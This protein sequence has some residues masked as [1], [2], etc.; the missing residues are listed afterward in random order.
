MRDYFVALA[1]DGALVWIYRTR[2]PGPAADAGGG[3]TTAAG[4]CTGALPEGALPAQHDAGL[5]ASRRTGIV[6][7]SMPTHDIFISYRRSDSAGHARAL[8][9]DLAR[10]FD[11]ERIYFDRQTVD[12]GTVYTPKI[13]AAVQAAPVVLVMIGPGWLDTAEAQGRRRLD[14]PADLVRQEVALALQS[15][16]HVIPVLFDDVP[17]PAAA[18]LPPPLQALAGRDAH[19]LRGKNYEYEVQL[20]QLIALIAAVP[21]VTPARE[22]GVLLARGPGEFE[23]YRGLHYAPVRLRAPLRRA[24]DPLVEDRTRIFAGRRQELTRLMDFAAGDEEG[25]LVVTGPPGFGKTALVATLV[26]GTPEAFAYHFFAPVYGA[27][28]LDEKFFLQNVLEQMASWQGAPVELPDDLNALRALYQQFLESGADDGRRQVLVLDGLD[29]ISSWSLRAYLSRRLPPQLRVIATV[30]DVGQD[31][32]SEFGIPAE[33]L[34]TL[35]LDGLQPDDIRE[36]LASQGAAAAQV[37]SEASLMAQ[38]VERAAYEADAALG[39]DPFYVRFLAEDLASGVLK[40]AEVGLQPRGLQ[41]WLDRWWQQLRA[42]AG[43]APVRD[44][45]GTLAAALGPIGRAELEAINPSLKD[46]WAGD[47]FDQILAGVRRFVRCDDEGGYTLAHPRLRTYVADARRI[48]AIERYRELLLAHCEARADAGRT[49]ALS[50]RVG[51]RLLAKQTQGIEM[52]FDADWISAQWRGLDSYAGLMADLRQAA[53]ALLAQATG[54][55]PV[56]A[57]L[58]QVTAPVVAMAIAHQTAREIMGNVPAALMAAWAAAGQTKRALKGLLAQGPARPYAFDALVDVARRLLERGDAGAARDAGALLERAVELLPRQRSDV[59]QLDALVAL[60]PLLRNDRAGLDPALCHALRRR[61]LEFAYTPADPVTLAGA[62][63]AVAQAFDAVT[64]RVDLQTQLERSRTLAADLAPPDHAH[65]LTLALPAWHAFDPAAACDQV[66]AL[67]ALGPKVTDHGSLRKNPLVR[68]IEA[69]DPLIDPATLHTLP[70]QQA[71]PLL[72]QITQLYLQPD[73]H[74]YA[75]AALSALLPML[76]RLGQA[77]AAL[78]HIERLMARDEIGALRSILAAWTTL[79]ALAPARCKQWLEQAVVRVD[80]PRHQL[81]YNRDTFAADVACCLAREQ[82]WDEALALMATL[83]PTHARDAFAA[84]LAAARQGP[85]AMRDATVERIVATLDTTGAAL[86]GKDRAEVLTA[87]AQG[88]APDAAARWLAAATAACLVEVPDGSLDKLRLAH[89]GALVEDGS[90]EA[91]L[92]VAAAMQWPGACGEAIRL[93][94]HHA[95]A[96]AQDACALALIQSVRRHEGAG[97]LPEL[98]GHAVTAVQDLPMSQ[99]SR[100]PLI[101]A[102]GTAL[103]QLRDEDA[104]VLLWQL[105]EPADGGLPIERQCDIL[106]NSMESLG[107]RGEL[108]LAVVGQA[109]SA[110]AR[111]RDVLVPA[112]ETLHGRLRE[113]LAKLAADDSR[114]EVRVAQCRHEAL[115]D[116][117]AGLAAL[118]RLVPEI[119]AGRDVADVSYLMRMLADFTGKAAGRRQVQAQRVEELAGAAVEWLLP[120]GL[121]V[122]DVAHALQ[123]VIDAALAIDDERDRARALVGVTGALGLAPPALAEALAPVLQSW[124]QAPPVQAPAL[125]GA[126][127]Q[128]VAEGLCQAGALGL[129]RML[130][131]L[132]EAATAPWQPAFESELSDAERLAELTPLGPFD[133]A[134]MALRERGLALL[135]LHDCRIRGEAATNLGSLLAAIVDDDGS[136]GRSRLLSSV[137]PFVAVPLRTLG[138]SATIAEVIAQVERLD[139]TLIDAAA[140]VRDAG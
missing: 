102:I 107:A 46:D 59:G 84:L 19:L 118:E 75:H 73:A 28:T 6:G 4:S 9:R 35:A 86:G 130:A 114:L 13:Q 62:Q 112:N 63:A 53:H 51:H 108:E 31:W 138:G 113:L 103:E 132:P 37:A 117:A 137:V 60:A 30:R 127:A 81:A 67:L 50:Y 94:Q 57:A 106:L 77:D 41:S 97:L 87:A 71:L 111:L 61:T 64:E 128:G 7:A 56:A 129:A 123:Q 69:W 34:H 140:R 40:P 92:A 96:A 99:P 91:A 32:R 16:H 23:V 104:L 78:A 39:A 47:R 18:Q 66:Q 70:T 1:H 29:E 48:G 17:V 85:P 115:R 131:A 116:P 68:L 36:L 25:Y 83:G 74:E 80:D 98:L 122:S 100:T 14:D 33:Q 133:A 21:G 135:C 10:R 90:F 93:V 110:L 126:L 20:E 38:V 124:V 76:C 24:F 109:I 8:H 101:L 12:A 54:T 43:D 42:L 49:Y 5:T 52:L 22:P 79:S 95:G 65:V 27:Q 82:R 15:G 125:L 55:P 3:P 58:Q 120:A 89:V 2:L 105:V 119:A 72:Q 45:F 26:A 121:P 139:K 136:L 44:L 11:V 88:A 134:I